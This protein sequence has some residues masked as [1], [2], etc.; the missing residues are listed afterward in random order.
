MTLLHK[1]RL[2]SNV[3]AYVGLSEGRPTSDQAGEASKNSKRQSHQ[4]SAKGD[5]EGRAGCRER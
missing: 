1:W 2:V 4:G 3:A 5:K